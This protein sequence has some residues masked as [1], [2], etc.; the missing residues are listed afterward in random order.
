MRRIATI[1]GLLF[2]VLSTSSCGIS[3]NTYLLR[4]NTCDEGKKVT[5]LRDVASTSL[6]DLREFVGLLEIP[7]AEKEYIYEQWQDLGPWKIKDGYEYHSGLESLKRIHRESEHYRLLEEKGEHPI[8][9][10]AEKGYI[11]AVEICLALGVDTNTRGEFKQTPIFKAVNSEVATLLL[12]NGAEINAK[13]IS[14]DTPLHEVVMHGK[15]EMAKFLLENG[16][17]VNA[18]AELSFRNTPLHVSVKVKKPD[19]EIVKLLL[20]HGA[21]INALSDSG[22]SALSYAHE[23]GYDEIELLLM[24]RGAKLPENK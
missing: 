16:A 19:I 12:K 22:E 17:D 20:D 3:I 2:A 9:K 11:T 24:Q 14:G 23:F 1:I 7:S 4:Y 10:A 21:D 5:V 6:E 8:F 15:R 18:V 13:D